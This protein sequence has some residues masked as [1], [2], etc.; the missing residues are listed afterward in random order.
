MKKYVAISIVVMFLSGCGPMPPNTYGTETFAQV[1]K[2][3]ESYRTTLLAFQGEVLQAEENQEGTFFQILVG[4][5][6]AS[7][8]IVHYPET[9]NSIA[10]GR[11]VSVLGY[12][13][14]KISGSNMFGGMVSTVTFE[15]I[16]VDDWAQGSN[17]T[18]DPVLN[19][20]WLSGKPVHLLKSNEQ[21]ENE[22]NIAKQKQTK[23]V[24]HDQRE[25]NLQDVQAKV[26]GNGDEWTIIEKKPGAVRTWIT[27]IDGSNIVGGY[28]TAFNCPTHGFLY[29]G[30]TWTTLDMPGA[31]STSISGIN[32]NKIVGDYT[33]A[34][35]K[36]H[37]FIYKLP[38]SAKVHIL[39]VP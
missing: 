36:S 6:S 13:G 30:T 15:A 28:E 32:G 37:R 2:N 27:G 20:Q 7:S 39:S 34:S 21:L 19:Q 9:C 11:H 14:G 1:E 23:K 33:D 16:S 25:L 35:R 31:I 22:N 38:K 26:I 17:C 24:E 18:T 5:E 10:R 4:Y 12:P 29:N 8:L 3:P